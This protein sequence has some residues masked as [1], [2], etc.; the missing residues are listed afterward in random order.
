MFSPCFLS[1]SSVAVTRCTRTEVWGK[2]CVKAPVSAE[3]QKHDEIN[4]Y[5]EGTSSSQLHFKVQSKIK[6]KNENCPIKRRC[7]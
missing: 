3:Q 1:P 7:H 2:K 5:T 6:H 4:G